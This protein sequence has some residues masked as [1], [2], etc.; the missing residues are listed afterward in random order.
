MR[1]RLLT[2]LLL[3]LTLG[4]SSTYLQVEAQQTNRSVISGKA[5]ARAKAQAES[6]ER[7]LKSNGYNPSLYRDD[8]VYTLNFKSKGYDINAVVRTEQNLIGLY[9]LHPVHPE[10]NYFAGLYAS[11]EVTRKTLV[12]S[13]YKYDEQNTLHGI[14]HAWYVVGFPTSIPEE[15]LETAI[16]EL[17]DALEVWNAAYNEGVSALNKEAKETKTSNVI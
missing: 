16:N 9:I 7:W 1:K 8:E 12:S 5:R 15:F 6:I 13:W 17:H 14:Y 4:L 2:Y 10:I 11:D 3:T